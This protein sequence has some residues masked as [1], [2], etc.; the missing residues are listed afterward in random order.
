MVK[1]LINK[2]TLHTYADPRINWTK[3]ALWSTVSVDIVIEIYF[4]LYK[5]IWHDY[6]FSLLCKNM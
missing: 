6:L 1:N 4:H 3:A 2:D 5:N